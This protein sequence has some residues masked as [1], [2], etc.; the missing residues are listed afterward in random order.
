MRIIGFDDL[1]DEYNNDDYNH[2]IKLWQA[3]MWIER[4]NDL[5]RDADLTTWL[6]PNNLDL[7]ALVDERYDWADDEYNT[8]E[9]RLSDREHYPTSSKFHHVVAWLCQILAVTIGLEDE[10]QLPYWKI[11]DEM[12]TRVPAELSSSD[13]NKIRTAAQT[14]MGLRPHVFPSIDDIASAKQEMK[15]LTKLAK[16]EKAGFNP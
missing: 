13:W 10:S 8:I 11:V 3:G 2:L 1:E 15:D 7:Q 16:Q 4:P 9:N 14:V 6:D 5:G 12:D